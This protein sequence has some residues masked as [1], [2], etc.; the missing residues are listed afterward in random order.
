M[1]IQ[2]AAGKPFPRPVDPVAPVVYPNGTQAKSVFNALVVY[3]TPQG[4]SIFID[5]LDF[6]PMELLLFGCDYPIKV[7]G[8]QQFGSDTYVAAS[9]AL[10]PQKF[11][12]ESQAFP[13][14]NTFPSSLSFPFLQTILPTAPPV[15]YQQIV[16][17]TTATEGLRV[18]GFPYAISI[19]RR[20]LWTVDGNVGGATA[21]YALTLDV[22]LNS[23][24]NIGPGSAFDLSGDGGLVVPIFRVPVILW[25][26]DFTQAVVDA[27]YTISTTF[28]GSLVVFDVVGLWA[29][30]GYSPVGG[31]VQGQKAA[32]RGAE[33]APSPFSATLADLRKRLFSK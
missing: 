27:S 4:Y 30:E 10:V 2:N 28:N 18:S 22:T 20:N 31:M 9:T 21:P 19:P 1:P 24:S 16:T 25:E 23:G 29:A 13:L 8:V 15:R 12:I 32:L 14:F 26:P 5:A 3:N 33:P 17:S 6:S 7:S 11:P